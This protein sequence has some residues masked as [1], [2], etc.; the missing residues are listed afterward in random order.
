MEGVLISAG[1]ACLIA[2]TVGGGLK[3]FQ[4]EIPLLA[5]TKR[6]ILL[7]LLGTAFLAI[8]L[9][10]LTQLSSTPDSAGAKPLEDPVNDSIEAGK[11][12]DD[13]TERKIQLTVYMH[14]L[15]KRDADP[16]HS[17]DDSLKLMNAMEAM[18]LQFSGNTHQLRVSVFDRLA[19]I[20][21]R[22]ELDAIIQ[23]VEQ[24]TGDVI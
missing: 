24:S 2:A 4:I 21:T 3:A 19:K 9:L 5:S 7:A 8:G 22:Q 20:R 18:D 17:D 13:F 11:D 23:K 12:A 16:A 6:Q 1:A 15:L 10:D 14:D